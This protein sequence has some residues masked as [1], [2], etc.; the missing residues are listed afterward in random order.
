MLALLEGN[1]KNGN[2]K[3]LFDNCD[4]LVQLARQLAS[5]DLAV[6]CFE[7][8]VHQVRKRVLPRRLRPRLR[9]DRGCVLSHL[10][11]SSRESSCQVER[12][13]EGEVEKTCSVM[14]ELLD[15]LF[16][17]VRSAGLG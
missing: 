5:V 3:Q 8:F 13:A 14:D 10:C 4:A 17:P 6:D 1:E 7:P 9:S 11:P 15:A 16:E 12:E 2:R